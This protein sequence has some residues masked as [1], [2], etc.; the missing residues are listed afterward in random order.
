MRFLGIGLVVY[1]VLGVAVI[2]TALVLGVPAVG[3]A[4][5][6]IGSVDATV[7]SATS[8]A[9][10]AAEAFTSFN[11]NLDEARGAA[12]DAATLSRQASATLDALA[13]AMS[14]SIFGTQPLAPLAGNVQDSAAQLDNLGGDLEHLG[15]AMNA[16]QSDVQ[17]IGAEL[18]RVA[19]N[20][21]TLHR[22]VGT[23]SVIP[24]VALLYAVLIWLLLPAVASLVG[25]IW[26]LRRP[27]AGHGVVV[28]AA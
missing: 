21:A 22:R 13:S 2:G 9:D 28:E 18:R 12:G 19:D 27:V 1:G 4:Q 17:R 3:R 16:S 5:R 26:L 23:G 15:T 24:S 6:L 20:L 11:G 8:A 10:A 14:L 7:Q 25:G